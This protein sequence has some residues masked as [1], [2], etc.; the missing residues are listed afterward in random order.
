MAECQRHRG[1]FSEYLDGVL[2]PQE[3]R[4]L[5]A[6]LAGCAACRREL[7]AWRHLIADVS[8]L[9]G[10]D[11]PDGFTAR[12]LDRLPG[13][14]SAPATPTVSLFWHRALP[15]AAMILVVLGLTFAVNRPVVPKAG[16]EGRLAMAQKE[17]ADEGGVH[18]VAEDGTALKTNELR[19]LA[20][21]PAAPT[22]GFAVGADDGPGGLRRR[23]AQAVP[24]RASGLAAEAAD[25]EAMHPTLGMSWR[26]IEPGDA[27]A[28]SGQAPTLQFFSQMAP[29]ETA[30]VRMRPQQV[31]T[32]TADDQATLASRVVVIAN[33]NGVQPALVLGAGGGKGAMEVHLRVPAPR[34]VTV[35]RQL[36]NLTTPQRQSLVNTDA[37]EGAFFAEALRDYDAHLGRQFSEGEAEAAAEAPARVV[38]LGPMAAEEKRAESSTRG[39]R[40]ARTV[41]GGPAALRETEA[42]TADQVTGDLTLV[43]RVVPPESTEPAGR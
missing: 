28:A 1:K 39:G 14:R 16:P 4:A 6:H 27:S 29:G 36:S 12:V 10:P 31:L 20:G 21:E 33:A 18:M 5:R 42:P 19:S 41:A 17:L 37:A 34:Y 40:R 38:R 23:R 3:R 8:R 26:M 2:D 43:V 11:A 22:P 30:G 13:P 7:L 15:V 35:L 24:L 9:P 32:L 25:G